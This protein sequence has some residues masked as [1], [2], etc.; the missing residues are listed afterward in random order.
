MRKF[1]KNKWKTFLVIFIVVATLFY[2]LIFDGSK[3]PFLVSF[4]SAFLILFIK[5]V[6]S[7][8]RAVKIFIIFIILRE[9]AGM[10]GKDD[11]FMYKTV[12]TSIL[13]VL[14]SGAWIVYL[15]INLKEVI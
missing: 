10:D 9:V 13:F 15:I 11:K 8:I 3:I 2:Y 7:M 1:L 6:M 4:I 12:L 5:C 14:L